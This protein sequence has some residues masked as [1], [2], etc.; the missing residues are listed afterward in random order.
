MQA[1]VPL[2]PRNLKCVLPEL[3]LLKQRDFAFWKRGRENYLS[4]YEERRKNR[5]ATKVDP[6]RDKET[7][8]M[9]G[10]RGETGACE[11]GCGRRERPWCG[12][13]RG[14]TVE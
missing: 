7:Q 12:A 5:T 4:I 2:Q 10:R 11:L 9:Q 3:H 6:A 14:K 13:P 1:S 8:H